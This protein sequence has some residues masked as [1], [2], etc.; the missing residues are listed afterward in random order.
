MFD[1]GR[2]G[3]DSFLFG[4]DVD[5]GGDGDD[6]DDGDARLRDGLLVQQV[7]A[8]VGP[9]YRRLALCLVFLSKSFLKALISIFF[10][11]IHNF[12]RFFSI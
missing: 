4:F 12:S 3:N 5:V 7:V 1:S 10:R 9:S 6:G 8:A 11:K 2:S